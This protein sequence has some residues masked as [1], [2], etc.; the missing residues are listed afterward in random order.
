M[1]TID[2]KALNLSEIIIYNRVTELGEDRIALLLR[3]ADE[4][5]EKT[6]VIYSDENLD[7]IIKG[8]K[9]ISTIEL[10]ENNRIKVKYEDETEVVFPN[11]LL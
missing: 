8:M 11:R 6:R 5:L 9:Q 2:G 1:T 3:H 10:D 4:T 7:E